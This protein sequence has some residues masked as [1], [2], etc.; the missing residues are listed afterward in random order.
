MPARG[1]L[2]ELVKL[3]PTTR[4]IQSKMM[5]SRSLD[6]RVTRGNLL[7][8]LRVNSISFSVRGLLALVAMC[9]TLISVDVAHAELPKDIERIQKVYKGIEGNASATEMVDLF[10][11]MVRENARD[12]ARSEGIYGLGQFSRDSFSQLVSSQVAGVRKPANMP[13]KYLRRVVLME[14]LRQFST[15]DAAHK[16]I[17]KFL[18][19]PPAGST[20]K[21]S[22]TSTQATGKSQV[23]M[24]SSDGRLE[25]FIDD[26]FQ[27]TD[28]GGPGANNGVIDAGEWVNLG[29]K[30]RNRGPAPFFS[31]SGW[32][33]ESHQ[34][35]WSPAGSELVLPELPA[36]TPTKKPAE[37]KDGVPV[38]V[39]VYFSKEC[40][41]GTR[42]PVELTVRDT[43]RTLTRAIKLR[44]QVSVRNRGGGQK[45]RVVVDGDTPGH[46]D[47]GKAPPIRPDLKLELSHGVRSGSGAKGAR[48]NWSTEPDAGSLLSMN[49]FRADAP[50]Y[51][52]GNIWRA[53]DDLDI[54]AHPDDKLRQVH[55]KVIRGRKWRSPADAV[56]WFGTDTEI[57][58]DSPDGPEVVMKP[59][60]K[61]ICNNYLDDDGDGKP[62]CLD[63][64]CKKAKNCKSTARECPSVGA[65]STLA[66]TSA[67][68]AASPTRPALPNALAAVQPNYELLFDDKGFRKT[69]LCL[70]NGIPLAE[71]G[72][73]KCPSCKTKLEKT[74]DK[75]MEKTTQ[76]RHV[77][78]VYRHYLGLKVAPVPEICRDGVD[79]DLNGLVDVRDPACAPSTPQIVCGDGVVAGYEQCDDGNRTNGDGCNS[80]CRREVTR[81]AK[82]AAPPPP[83]APTPRQPIR[84]DLGMEFGGQTTDSDVANTINVESIQGVG[85]RLQGSYGLFTAGLTNLFQTYSFN[86]KDLTATDFQFM[87]GLAYLH[88][89]K[90]FDLEARGVLAYISREVEVPGSVFS[91]SRAVGSGAGLILSGLGR[92]RIT[93]NIGL[94]GNF[95]IVM[96][97]VVTKVGGDT[98]STGNTLRGGLGLS[99]LFD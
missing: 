21:A 59:K 53:G 38:S 19:L 87:A 41:N 36:S 84:I 10:A 99:L 16:A 35:A 40:A 80:S 29:F 25:A 1:E 98:F 95:D 78:Y 96:D 81:V 43:H 7:S 32:V 33:S 11:D 22:P 17:D 57:I 72:Q 67:S 69:Y 12:L 77:R 15:Q 60:K 54:Q 50:L 48:M 20:L 28:L 24:E 42:V 18:N 79:N 49:T 2:V 97:G 46:S 83:A 9:L 66:K 63:S 39:W 73:V 89:K 51:Q 68:I 52:E 26:S 6:E 31:A 45:N 85:F 94:Y 55:A 75:D 70:I 30:V 47:N 8:M 27:V 5:L 61:E 74:E 93:E 64:D 90:S 44:A 37:K 65:V 58:Y 91:G 23:R 88:R 56:M 4:F 92:Y 71:C 62:D 14:L 13:N 82:P 86:G 34:C 76:S 3:V